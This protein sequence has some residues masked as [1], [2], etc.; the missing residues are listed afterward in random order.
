[1][2]FD[3]DAAQF[4]FGGQKSSIILFIDESAHESQKAM[5]NEASDKLRADGLVVSF[6]QIKKDIG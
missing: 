6:S 2:E 5:L 3:Q 4:I 1:M